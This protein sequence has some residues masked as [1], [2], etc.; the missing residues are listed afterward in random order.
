[1]DAAWDR[2]H[3]FKGKSSNKKPHLKPVDITA[4]A[5]DVIQTLIATVQ[6]EPW[7]REISKER[8]EQEERTG[9]LKEEKTEEKEK[10]EE[11][12]EEKEEMNEE[13]VMNE[14]KGPMEEPEAEVVKEERQEMETTQRKPSDG[15]TR[16]EP[17][18]VAS[19]IE[20]GMYHVTHSLEPSVVI[21]QTASRESIPLSLEDV[22]HLLNGVGEEEPEEEGVW[23]YIDAQGFER[24]P[25]DSSTMRAWWDNGFLTQSL[26]VKYKEGSWRPIQTCYTSL[27]NVFLEPPMEEMS[28]KLAWKEPMRHSATERRVSDARRV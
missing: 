5:V 19:P 10:T 16:Q 25:F 21:Q 23:R 13:K 6:Q 22:D 7:G 17:K 24:G 3:I 2:C 27:E 4:E 8:E 9:K 12:K 11:L 18:P 1:M 14:A 20:L 26:V 28:A 15:E